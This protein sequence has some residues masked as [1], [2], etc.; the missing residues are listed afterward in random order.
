MKLVKAS[1][2]NG[3]WLNSRFE[4][5]KLP[6][7]FVLPSRHEGDMFMPTPCIAYG[8]RLPTK[9]FPPKREDGVFEDKHKYTAY[10]SQVAIE[11]HEDYGS[12]GHVEYQFMNQ[13]A[14]MYENEIPKNFKEYRELLHDVWEM[15]KEQRDPAEQL[16]LYRYSWLSW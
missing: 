10:H 5:C 14:V 4:I 12:D 3:E 2:F 15:E 11:I 9:D 13:L 8:Y 6:T 16:T 1:E 7:E